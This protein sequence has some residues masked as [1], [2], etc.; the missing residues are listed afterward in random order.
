MKR[1]LKTLERL[2]NVYETIEELREAEAQHAI[3]EVREAE[4]A[5]DRQTAMVREAAGEERH[6]LAEGDRMGWS[7]AMARQ[8]V[9]GVRRKALGPVLAEREKRSN[10][11]N[12]RHVETHLWSE[13]MKALVRGVRDEIEEKEQRGLQAKAD[14]RFLAQRRLKKPRGDVPDGMSELS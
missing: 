10:I 8:S 5:I 6:A 3:G 13:R 9:A 12:R 2:L 1:R 4:R 11:A 14:E 7:Y